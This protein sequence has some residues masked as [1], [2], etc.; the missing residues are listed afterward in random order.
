[1]S[2]DPAAASPGWL[3]TEARRLLDRADETTA[4]RWS[5]AAALLARQALESAVATM[6]A[7]RAPGA[8]RCSARAQLLCL[9]QLIDPNQAF[10]IEHAW[11]GLSR[12]CHHHAYELPPTAVEL[13][14]W[15]DIVVALASAQEDRPE[16]RHGDPLGDHASRWRGG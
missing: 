12:A 3:L 16:L 10:A 6:L 11:V 13:A 9:R 5:R 14:G 2:T 8:E 1:M 15:L 4:G 7:E